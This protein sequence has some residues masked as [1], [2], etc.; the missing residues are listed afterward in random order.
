MASSRPVAARTAV[1]QAGFVKDLG[2][3]PGLGS[4]KAGR[5]LNPP[6]CERRFKGN[7]SSERGVLI[8][9]PIVSRCC[10]IAHCSEAQPQ[11]LPLPGMVSVPF[12]VQV[13]RTH[14]LHEALEIGCEFYNSLRRPLVSSHPVKG[15][16]V[17]E[18]AAVCRPDDRR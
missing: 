8:L 2:T 7:F 6:W 10:A 1:G 13:L 3:Y 9:L 16:V 4:R 17:G 15:Y 12:H 18:L 11:I 14:L 5:P